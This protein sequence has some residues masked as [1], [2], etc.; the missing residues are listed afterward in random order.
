MTAK[1]RNAMSEDEQLSRSDEYRIMDY[2]FHF[3]SSIRKRNFELMTKAL[4]PYELNPKEWRILASL[5]EHGTQSVTELADIAL[6]ERTRASRIVD[7]LFHVGMVERLTNESDK[8]YA[9]VNLTS[10]GKNKYKEVS[11]I[12]AGLH[13]R[14][15]T[16]VTQEEYD[17]FMRVLKRMK[18]N[19]LGI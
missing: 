7:K 11:H 10:K 3:M 16:D 9:L 14:I 19:S 4:R 18:M 6:L 2:P 1:M 13:S 15:L 8:R 12:V 5:N 17:I